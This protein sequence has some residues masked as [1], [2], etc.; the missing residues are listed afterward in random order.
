MQE[1]EREA[2]MGGSD[3]RPTTDACELLI[4]WSGPVMLF[5]GAE[6]QKGEICSV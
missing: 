1:E 5:R 4:H 6:E 2:E 3:G